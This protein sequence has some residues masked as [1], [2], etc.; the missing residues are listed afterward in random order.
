VVYA[1]PGQST[2][3]PAAGAAV[4]LLG[5]GLTA[6]A[7]KDGAFL[8]EGI[9][10]ASGQLLLRFGVSG[11]GQ[12]TH[13]RLLDLGALGAGPGKQIGLGDVTVSEN[14]LLHGR[15]LRGDV[16]APSGHGGTVVYVPQGPYTTYTGDDGT[17]QLRDLPAG[18]LSIAFFRIGYQTVSVDAISLQSG[19]DFALRDQTLGLGAGG[20]STA[21]ATIGGHVS[22]NPPA[23]AAGTSVVA[24][25][26]AGNSVAGSVT[27]EGDFTV[28]GAPAGL[29]QLTVAQAGYLPARLSNLLLA[30]GQTL[31]LPGI[32]LV[33]VATGGGGACVAGAFCQPANLCR[34]GQVDCSSGSATCAELGNALDGTACGGGAVCSGGACIPFCVGGG[35]CQ[36]ANACHLGVVTCSAAGPVCSDTGSGQPN[37]TS[38]GPS[39]VCTSGACG[40]CSGAS[41]CT[42]A[43]VPA[44]P[45]HRGTQA[46]GGSSGCADT[47]AAVDNGTG[48]GTN[49]VCLAGSCVGCVAGAA[50]QP[51]NPCKTGVTSCASGISVCAETGS[52]PDSTSCGAPDICRG[53]T[54]VAPTA[55]ISALVRAAVPP[56]ATDPNRP[57]GIA[58]AR[59]GDVYFSD[60]NHHQ[61][62]RISGGAVSVVAGTGACGHAGDGGPADQA[63]LCTP[64]GL[65]LD[66][67]AVPPLL[68]VS[69][70]GSD[71]VRVIQLAAGANIIAPFAGGGSAPAPGYGDGGPATG[72]LLAQPTHLALGY[73]GSPP[74]Q[75]LYLSDSGHNRV[76]RVATQS[77]I[78]STVLA[79]PATDCS[80][81]VVF[82]SCA[83]EFGCSLALDAQ[84]S[85]F[86]SGQLC[87]TELISYAYG[88]ARILPGG[89]LAPVAGKYQGSASDGINARSAA[90]VAPPALAFDAAGNLFAADNG[91]NTVRR[92]DGATGRIS[93]AVGTG[94]ASSTGDGGDAQAATVNG[95]WGIAFDPV[96]RL[97][98]VLTEYTGNAV[99]RVVNAGSATPPQAGLAAAGGTSQSLLVDQRA[100]TPLAVKL[101]DGGGAPLAGWEILFTSLSPAGAIYTPAST[102]A[103][104]GITSSAARVGLAPAAYSFQASFQDIHGFDVAGSP[105]RFDLAA[106][107]PA[108]GTLFN[109]VNDESG[110]AAGNTGT[111]G[112]GALARINAPR[113]VQ[114]AS[115]GTVYFA[116]SNNNQV[117][118]LSPG[119]IL[120]LVAGSGTCGF[121][122]DAGQAT[123]AMLCQPKGLA[124]DET[125]PRRLYIADAN[126][127]RVRAVNL[128]TGIID[129]VAGGGPSPGAAPW[130]DGGPATSAT[131]SGPT[132]VRLRGSTLYVAD[133]GHNRIR[134]VDLSLAVPTI[135]TWLAPGSPVDC[136]APA[137][138]NACAGETGC[139]VGWDASGK[140][141]VSGQF[142][143]TSF[144]SYAFAVCS[145][146]GASL[147]QVVGFYNGGTGE[148]A[149]ANRAQ[150]PAVPTISFAPSGW[151]VLTMPGGGDRVRYVD[152]PGSP[153]ARVFT[154]AG[155]G[156]AGYGGE[157]VPLPSDSNAQLNNPWEVAFGPSGRAAIADTSNHALRLVW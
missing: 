9:A 126:S 70:Y 99:R 109:A 14:A 71:L 41:C 140:A 45:C 21:P 115:D 4:E 147:A 153:G 44:N 104:N 23:S 111:G 27:A 125:P 32:V 119:G 152:S 114:V 156:V 141:Y 8:L 1:L 12:A 93:T 16:S 94:A 13:Q 22:F 17:Y 95:P 20:G 134:T 131:L 49:Q 64:R 96:Q 7:D 3:Q 15:A 135:S 151:L 35:G 121:G 65:A 36:P 101:T 85:L 144:V 30:P 43:C 113:G 47:G 122:G 116:D 75:N 68:Y 146:D 124:L 24:V 61:V 73:E 91:G 39:S 137:A 56:A 55:T 112:P 155:S 87:G 92:I 110:R 58:V 63:T 133:S 89:A 128:T 18:T 123:Q 148:G 5:A 88:I 100:A 127:D 142:C 19:Q 81:P 103:L 62:K 40:P 46:C 51:D 38:C 132:H 83:G 29:Y 2:K 69:D 86:V 102:T 80:Q 66:E 25:D 84:G 130:G 10:S 76:R 157:Y 117:K 97:D 105:V 11:T 82:N 31:D 48:C 54:C 52:L 79:G 26:G 42:S 53:G 154:W 37:G 60:T 136:T 28:A 149:A 59:N 33:G 107:A 129:L 6:T 72:A 106:A 90:F 145:F 74:V 139:D 108:A 150:L 138:F 143:G 50:C 120:T 78:I 34:A 77:G 67:A 98:L 57:S 118:A